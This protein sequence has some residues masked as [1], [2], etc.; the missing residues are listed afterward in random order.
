MSRARPRCIGCVFGSAGGLMFF[1]KQKTAY[2]MRISDWSSDVC[3]SDRLQKI[4][5]MLFPNPERGDPFWAE[6][7]RTGFIGVG[8]YV[9][10]MPHRPFSIGEIYRTMTQGDPKTTLPKLV[11]EAAAAGMQLSTPCLN[12]IRSEEHTSELQSLM[13]ISYAVFCLKNTK[14]N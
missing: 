1:F 3:S 11:E 6:S 4:A 7:A 5:V 10:A 9:A 12:A 2:D 14:T 13:R 8:A